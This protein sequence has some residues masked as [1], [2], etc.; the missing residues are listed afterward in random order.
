VVSDTSPEDLRFFL[1]NDAPIVRIERQTLAALPG[2]PSTTLRPFQELQLES[3][4]IEKQ[5][6]LA[7]LVLD[8]SLE[9]AHGVR[10]FTVTEGG[11]TPA[12]SQIVVAVGFPCDISRVNHLGERVIFTH[13]EWTEIVGPRG[14]LDGFDQAT[15]ALA[16]FSIT[17]ELPE[18]DPRGMSGA[19]VWWQ[20][21]AQSGVWYPNLELAGITISY[22]EKSKLLKFVKREFVE[23]FL[24]ML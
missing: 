4:V 9:K 15:H 24:T 2:V 10:S 12:S 23:A 17:D 16:P 5:L 8:D 22:Y 19:A 1:R 20:R 7:A 6:D 18:A 14:G 21:P 3:L 13:V 11:N